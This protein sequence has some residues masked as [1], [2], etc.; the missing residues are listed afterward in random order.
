MEGK[1]RDHVKMFQEVRKL[2]RHYD[3]T[4][5]R[6][7]KTPRAS[8]LGAVPAKCDGCN[9]FVFAEFLEDSKGLIALVCPNCKSVCRYDND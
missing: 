4:Q 9:N 6:F 8:E 7:Y 2:E 3:D 5:E 1:R